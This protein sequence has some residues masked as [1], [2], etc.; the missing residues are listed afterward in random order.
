MIPA[1][2]HDNPISAMSLE[3]WI[4]RSKRGAYNVEGRYEGF[5]IPEYLVREFMK[6]KVVVSR[7]TVN[8]A[9][10]VLRDKA[11]DV[12]RDDDRMMYTL[13]ADILKKALQQ[14]TPTPLESKV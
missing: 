8:L 7:T 9:E 10:A 13:A 6:G 2:E 1:A 12:E 5:M 4:N 3:E 14:S 11:E